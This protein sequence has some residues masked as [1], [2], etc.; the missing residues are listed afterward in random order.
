MK[1]KVILISALILAGSVSAQDARM[2]NQT[3]QAM[4]H[5][6]VPVQIITQAIKTASLISF[7]IN[8]QEF[9]GLVTAGASANDA[10]EITKAMDERANSH[11]AIAVVPVAMVTP[12]VRVPI[13]APPP[14]AVAPVV[15]TSPVPV[16][17]VTP[18]PVPV[19]SPAVLPSQSP[20]PTPVL[21]AGTK[22]YIELDKGFE[23]YIAAAM[24]KKHVPIVVT[25]NESDAEFVLVNAVHETP[26]TSGLGKFARCAFAYCIGIDGT[27]TATVEMM[28]KKREVVWAYNVRKGGSGNY[29]SSAEAIAKHLK[30]F[31]K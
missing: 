13:P 5:G 21:V 28:N 4:V 10:T 7:N 20:V 27:Q 8:K 9:D 30:S 24:V 1:S 6:G 17:A 16:L 12:S 15:P 18:A 26:E 31:I 2:T 14:V 29:Q 22:I 3:I 11:G 23:S 25:A 19:P